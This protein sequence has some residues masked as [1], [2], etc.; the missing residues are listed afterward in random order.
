M[1]EIPEIPDMFEAMD[2]TEEVVEEI[3]TAPLK[4]VKGTRRALRNLFR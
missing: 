2:K 1:P 4:L 3:V